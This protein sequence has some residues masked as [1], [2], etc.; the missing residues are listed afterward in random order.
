MILA[1][2]LLDN[3][4][5]MSS[6][7]IQ[8]VRDDSKALTRMVL[9]KITVIEGQELPYVHAPTE[10]TEDDILKLQKQVLTRAEHLMRQIA[11]VHAVNQI[12]LAHWQ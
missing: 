9:E 10:I 8:L 5:N 1:S 3:P 4:S 6:T 2:V 7:F 11:N 12:E